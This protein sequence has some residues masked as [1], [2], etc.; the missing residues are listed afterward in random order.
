MSKI[1]AALL[2]VILL[3]E[4]VIKAE[5]PN[6]PNLNISPCKT[7]PII[8]GEL[9]DS[10]WKNAATVNKF[11]IIGKNK[12]I[13]K[14][15]IF[16]TCDN[17][18]LYVGFDVKQSAMER[19]APKYV[20][21]HDD[22]VQR[23]DC[24]KF[25]FDPGTDGKIWYHFKAN[26][27]NVK[28]DIRILNNRQEIFSWNIPWRSAI[29]NN[30][31]NWTAEFAIPLCL[32]YPFDN[33]KNA[34]MNLLISSYVPE[35][36]AQGVVVHAPKATRYSWA[37]VVKNFAEPDNFGKISGLDKINIKA[38]FLPYIE[39]A[40]IAK[41]FQKNGKFY[42]GIDIKLK[43]YTS[44]P[45]KVNLEIIDQTFDGKVK[46]INQ[47]L[48]FP[49]NGN[50][51]NYRIAIPVDTMV[52]RQTLLAV[53]N[54][55][56][57]EIL[58]NLKF[59]DKNM[60]ALDLFSAYI[61]RNYYTTEKNAI[62]V[63]NI[64]LPE[65]AMKE[66]YLSA[67]NT[68]GREIA[69]SGKVKPDTY[70]EIPLARIK[71]FGKNIITVK[72]CDFPK[73]TVSSLKLNLIKLKPKP[74]CEWKIDH[75]NQTLLNNG[76]PIFGFGFIGQFSP[77]DKDTFKM[78]KDSGCNMVIA[79][80][81]WQGLDS[82]KQIPQVI[83]SAGEFGLYVVPA[84]DTMSC[85][86]C[87]KLD[88]LKKYFPDKQPLT[89]INYSRM[90]SL[91]ISGIYKKLPRIAKNEI[92]DAYVKK[93]LPY[94]IQGV[95]AC[96]NTDNLMG[97]FIFDEPCLSVFDQWKT[98]N[99]VFN[100]INKSDGYH[101]VF[102]NYSSNIPKTPHA[103][104]W[105]NILMTDPYWIPGGERRNAPDFVS[106]VTRNM[107]RRATEHRQ[108]AWTIPMATF[109]SSSRKRP[110]L[111]REQMCQTYLAA[112]H[113]AKGV[114]Y[115]E[116]T[117]LN[118]KASWDALSTLAKQFKEALGPACTAPAVPNKITYRQ[119][120]KGKVAVFKI[121]DGS[122]KFPDVQVALKR[123]PN[124]G[125]ILMA[126]NSRYYPVKTTIKISG[127]KTDVKR[128]FKNNT[129]PV[130]N[131]TW[132]DNFEDFGVRAYHLDLPEINQ[133]YS[134]EVTAIPPN[135]IPPPERAFPGGWRRGHKNEFANPSFE[136][137]CFRGWPEY[138]F[139]SPFGKRR[140]GPFIGEPGAVW[141]I[142]YNEAKFGKKSMRIK[143]PFTTNGGKGRVYW[144]CNP[145]NRN[146][147]NYV[148]SAWM[149]AS[150]DNAKVQ[151]RVSNLK[152]KYVTVDKKWKRYSIK[153]KLPDAT[154][155]RKH[156]FY[157][158]MLRTDGDLWVD[159]VQLEKGTKAT[160]FEDK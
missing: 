95:D 8:D 130:K 126:A 111:P 10:C 116:Y 145:V 33:L 7:P 38:A 158:I 153:F 84:I 3:P 73:R 56:T 53:K 155:A 70:F 138:Y 93:N 36:D 124:R 5:H 87:P 42:Y 49:R 76:K 106:M 94:L 108:P 27:A 120:V 129:Y 14:N 9:N 132:T 122:D 30:E 11:E 23:D 2:A 104:D 75:I 52:K 102:I 140:K 118:D 152:I 66:M 131:E 133:P 18:W 54:P 78:L 51:K 19:V 115:Y 4:V 86:P 127:L 123:H 63:C 79:W 121:K 150:N 71:Q 43:P 17:K 60:E 57:G 113:G 69:R 109:W 97:Y 82:P 12:I 48:D 35:R 13:K 55:E 98:G 62:A 77:E 47:S 144:R 46:I 154:K 45:G 64:R 16:V 117:L 32:L 20:K 31:R 61:G 103:N 107:V 22:F 114:V 110:I 105:C 80:G 34:R 40:E 41:Y 58:Q 128:I 6:I 67:E 39:N 147:E 101:P 15:K 91:L 29:K 89:G 92:F 100:E 157:M 160:P 72:L 125:Y 151:M 83:Q 148:F 135:K 59:S 146:A 24:V 37:P 99:I 21:G 1:F 143:T 134:I 25:S 68:T 112:I 136:E 88:I 81:K 90:K 85:K 26:R 28:R 119:K 156:N 137:E 96:K 149:K 139:M 141:G 50:E 65:K 44:I 159:G 142:D 74:G